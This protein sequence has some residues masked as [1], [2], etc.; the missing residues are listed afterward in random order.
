MQNFV[1][2]HINEGDPLISY[3]TIN[4]NLDM[5]IAHI[6]AWEGTIVFEEKTASFFKKKKY[7]SF[8]N[9]YAKD[10]FF[11]EFCILF[12]NGSDK[13]AF[14]RIACAIFS[15][16]ALLFLQKEGFFNDL[17]SF[18][19]LMSILDSHFGDFHTAQTDRSYEILLKATKKAL[20]LVKS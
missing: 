2:K 8:R 15:Y 16:R 19:E 5:Q 11:K 18:K 6:E 7:V 4:N 12:E 20:K 10:K 17:N 3:S 1:L 13:V 9:K 14:I